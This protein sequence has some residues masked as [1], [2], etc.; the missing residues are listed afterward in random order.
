MCAQTHNIIIS[1]GMVVPNNER[2]T[3][4]YQIFR[5]SKHTLK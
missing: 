5:T 1:L 2:L 3:N 4:G